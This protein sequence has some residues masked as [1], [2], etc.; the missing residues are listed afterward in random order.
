MPSVPSRPDLT[1]LAARLPPRPRTRFAPSPTGFLHLGHIVNAVYVWGLAQALGGDVVLR[2]EDHDRVRSRPEFE[3]AILEDLEW[4]GLHVEADGAGGSATRASRHRQSVRDHIYVRALERLQAS[5]L[6]YGCACSRKQ[7]EELGQGDGDELRYPGTCRPAALP[8]TQGI[9]V[10]ARLV[11]GAE[12]FDDGLLGPQ[13]QVPAQQCGDLLVRDRVG[14]WTY[15]FAVTVDDAEQVIDLVI[16]GRDLLASTGRQI[17]LAR[18]LGRTTPPVFLHHPLVLAPTGAKLSK[19]NRDAGIRQLRAA[20]HQPADVLGLAAAAA[21]LL[22]SARAI[23]ASD[24]HTLFT[25]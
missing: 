9:G 22:P 23:T 8:L 7:I 11:D 25:P 12:A 16:R 18:M 21:S 14:G 20:G 24:L 17:Q 3:R 19:A 10:R 13:V 5:G 4:L 1:R 2:I 6:V 15:Q